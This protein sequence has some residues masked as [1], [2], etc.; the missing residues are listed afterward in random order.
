MLS[1]TIILWGFL[2]AVVIV[3]LATIFL[4]G[5]PLNYVGLM[6]SSYTALAGFTLLGI[7]WNSGIMFLAPY[8]LIVG[9]LALGCIYLSALLPL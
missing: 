4:E 9:G 7:E 2:A 6:A 5:K 8:F 3:V 1:P